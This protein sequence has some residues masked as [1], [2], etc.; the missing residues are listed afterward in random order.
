MNFTIDRFAL[1]TEREQVV[2]THLQDGL[3]P[4]EIAQVEYVG[5]TT[6]RTQIRSILMKLGVRSQLAAVAMANRQQPRCKTC[7]LN[8]VAAS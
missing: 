7:R 1:L 8:L 4:I 2:L 6:V 5:L 3:T